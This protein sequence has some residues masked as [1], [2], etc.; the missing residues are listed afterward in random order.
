MLVEQEKPLD[1]AWKYWH[2]CMRYLR[3]RKVVA[4]IVKQSSLLSWWLRYNQRF[5]NMTTATTEMPFP[6]AEYEPTVWMPGQ[7]VTERVSWFSGEIENKDVSDE[8]V[9]W[10]CRKGDDY[11]HLEV[12]W[13]LSWLSSGGGDLVRRGEPRRRLPVPTLQVEEQPLQKRCFW[14]VFQVCWLLWQH[15]KMTLIKTR[16]S[17]LNCALRDDEAVYWVSI[18][19]YEALAVGNWWY[20]VRRGHLCLYILHKVE[21]WKGVTHTWQTDWLTDNFER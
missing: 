5:A 9:Q 20:W 3:W 21:I 12:T 17:W 13:W 11:P 8:I 6:K 16:S 2:W 19:H 18:G 14:G 7:K 4:I 1:G 10:S 15:A